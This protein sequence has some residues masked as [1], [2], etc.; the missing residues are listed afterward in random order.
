MREAGFYYDGLNECLRHVDNSNLKIPFVQVN[1]LWYVVP[2]C[3]VE[4]EEDENLAAAAFE[5]AGD[6]TLCDQ[7]FEQRG[8]E[9]EDS[10]SPIVNDFV[11]GGE[12]SN[13]SQNYVSQ[14]QDAQAIE[15][16]QFDVED[17]EFSSEFVPENDSQLHDFQ[18]QAS[19]EDAILS[20][21]VE[22]D[23]QSGDAANSWTSFN[24]MQR[25]PQYEPY[26]SAQATFENQSRG[27][28]A[29]DKKNIWNMTHEE[30][31]AMSAEQYAE[32]DERECELKLSPEQIN[33]V[34]AAFNTVKPDSIEDCRKI[35]IELHVSLG[36]PC[37][38]ALK[39]AV[40][41]AD[42][43][44]LMKRRCHMLIDREGV[45]K[46]CPACIVGQSQSY[47]SKRSA[48]IPPEPM[49]K[50]CLDTT[51]L[52]EH[53]V[54]PDGKVYK[55]LMTATCAL[56]YFTLISPL[57]SLQDVHLEVAKLECRFKKLFQD[58]E[59]AKDLSFTPT[60]IL[61]FVMQNLLRLWP[62]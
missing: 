19:Q 13:L 6:N 30:F 25:F 9:V 24:E 53:C 26:N 21:E 27:C 57:V 7:A 29:F 12:N 40:D 38:M 43:S 16:L 37:D 3:N 36:H 20:E 54:G 5:D 56:T 48:P 2:I 51:P 44:I 58:Q 59:R 15:Q 23:N 22:L 42:M 61:N 60:Q 50:I 52:L 10:T 41:S 46:Q 28:V 31:F 47:H 14:A 49:W 1:K 35:L 4:T 32:D 17:S 33:E 62:R 39:Q 34:Y 55:Y 8:L 11:Q 45:G 18:D